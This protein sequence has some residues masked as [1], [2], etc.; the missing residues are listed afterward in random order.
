M[1]ITTPARTAP[2]RPSQSN[3][4]HV[5]CMKRRSVPRRIVIIPAE[6]C[7]ALIAL[8][9]R[10]ESGSALGVGSVLQDRGII[11]ERLGVI[12]LPANGQSYLRMLGMNVLPAQI[13]LFGQSYVRQIERAG[14]DLVSR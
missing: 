12:R 1:D 7:L 2:R 8:E 4:D 13:D 5:S 6:D 10:H 14:L 3:G 9:P 11:D